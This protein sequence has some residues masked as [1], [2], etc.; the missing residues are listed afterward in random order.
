MEYG[1]PETVERYTLYPAIC[2][3][4]SFQERDT[5]WVA[6][7]PVPVSGTPNVPFEALLVIVKVPESEPLAVGV[8]PTVNCTD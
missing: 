3:A 6:V 2:S 4:V 5:E 1:P 7:A 8:K